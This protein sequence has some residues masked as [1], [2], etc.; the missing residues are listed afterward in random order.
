MVQVSAGDFRSAHKLLLD[1]RRADLA[2]ALAE[3]CDEYG[4]ALSQPGP[5][6]AAAAAAAAAA[7]HRDKGG[8]QT[9]RGFVCAWATV[10]M[11]TSRICRPCTW[12]TPRTWT[13]W[14]CFPEACS[15]A[16]AHR[17]WQPGRRPRTHEQNAEQTAKSV[18]PRVCKN[19]P[20][21]PAVVV[22][23]ALVA[24]VGATHRRFLRT[25]RRFPRTRRRFRRAPIRQNGF[26]CCCTRTPQRTNN[27]TKSRGR[28]AR[29][30]SRTARER[31]AAMGRGGRLKTA[32]ECA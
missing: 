11:P 27:A 5:S 28:A 17:A 20:F 9:V 25:K 6:P 16:S 13:S 22:F 23:G 2:T 21:C 8:A 26:I 1:A 18:Q 31:G 19:R 7:A 14:A 3:C 24:V 29:Y 4:I 10:Q 15:T 30:E 12:R 32:C